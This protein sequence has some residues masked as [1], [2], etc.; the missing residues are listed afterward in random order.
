[1]GRRK[2]ICRSRRETGRPILVVEGETDPTVKHIDPEI[3]TLHNTFTLTDMNTKEIIY[4]FPIYGN[5]IGRLYSHLKYMVR[6]EKPWIF[7]WPIAISSLSYG[8]PSDIQRFVV[9]CMFRTVRVPFFH[10]RCSSWSVFII[11]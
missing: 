8:E 10:L 2:M 1:M 5:L 9:A 4:G 6:S 3:T 11:L 7:L